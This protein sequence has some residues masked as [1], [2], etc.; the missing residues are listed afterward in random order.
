MKG[1]I[2]DLSKWQRMIFKCEIIKKCGWTEYQYFE[3][4][5]GRTPLSHLERNACVEL[6]NHIKTQ[7]VYVEG[8]PT[9]G[10]PARN[11]LT[12]RKDEQKHLANGISHAHTL[13]AH[14][15]QKSRWQSG[16]TDKRE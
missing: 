6:A 16:K 15:K 7:S 4:L 11:P 2:T 14:S 10:D 5:S 13:Q 3:R 12:A 8:S 9:M 1:I